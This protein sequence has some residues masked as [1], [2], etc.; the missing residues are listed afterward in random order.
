MAIGHLTL[1]LSNKSEILCSAFEKW[2]LD[3]N[4]TIIN[5]CVIVRMKVLWYIIYVDY[6]KIE[7][8]RAFFFLYSGTTEIQGSCLPNCPIVKQ[9]RQF[10]CGVHTIPVDNL[11]QFARFP[12]QGEKLVHHLFLFYFIFIHLFILTP[13]QL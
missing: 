12:M 8:D 7:Y 1:T 13:M 11:F 5:L 3:K 6:W 10:S 2:W 9:H 4:I